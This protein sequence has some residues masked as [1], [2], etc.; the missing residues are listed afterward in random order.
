MKKKKETKTMESLVKEVEKNIFS[1]KFYPVAVKKEDKDE[2]VANIK[3]TYREGNETARQLLL[4]MIHENISE[5][6]EFKIAHTFEYMK[7]RNPQA[8]ASQ[9]RMNVY[10]KMFNYNTSLEGIVELLELLTE[11]E[12]DDSAKLLTYHYSRFCTMESEANIVLRNS[13]IEALGKSASPYALTALLKYAKN[14]DNERTLQRIVSALSQWDEKIDK[15]KMPAAEKK[16]LRKKLKDVL[17]K[18]L[19]VSHYG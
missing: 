18:E 6:M 1:I 9:L 12:G 5:F 8:E 15:V 2:A 7:A 11:F 10:K 16:K 4:Y 14:T 3:R 19:R 13:V 17:T